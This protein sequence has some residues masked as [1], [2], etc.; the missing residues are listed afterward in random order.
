MSDSIYRKLEESVKIIKEGVKVYKFFI[1][2][3]KLF[4]NENKFNVW[5]FRFFLLYL[6]KE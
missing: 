5:K 2:Y 6:K 1:W 4:F 3:I